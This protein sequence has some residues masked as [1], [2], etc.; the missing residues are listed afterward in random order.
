MWDHGRCDWFEFAFFCRE[1]AGLQALEQMV[2]TGAVDLALSGLSSD[3][4]MYRSQEM[5][6]LQ[7]AAYDY[8][9]PEHARRQMLDRMRRSAK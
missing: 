5:K 6:Q 9:T 7:T 3:G 2:L 1:L 4:D 8:W